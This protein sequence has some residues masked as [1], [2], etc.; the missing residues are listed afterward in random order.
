M[1]IVHSH[2]AFVAI[3][4]IALGTAHA[5]T[6][7]PYSTAVFDEP[8]TPK[9]AVTTDPIGL[10][11]GTYALSGTYV[12]SNRVGIRADVAVTAEMAGL[13]DSGSWRASINVPIYLDRALQGPYLEPGL[14]LANRF[15]GYSEGIGV[16]GGGS[17]DGIGGVGQ[18]STVYL[19]M[20]AQSFEPQIFVGWQW[21]YRSRM[22]IAGAI[23]A[24][25]HFATDG[26][27]ASFANPEMYLRVG[28]AF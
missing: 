7:D 14:A 26:S 28:L 10:I 27:G 23:G 16:L 8:T 15:M 9:L 24:S 11:T 2:L 20:H 19:P 13:P 21:L 4:V 1:P 12:V 3:T 18:M 22:S 17:T 6:I 5:D 25:R